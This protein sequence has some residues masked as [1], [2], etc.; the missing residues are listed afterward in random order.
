M[1]ISEQARRVLE[2]S[3]LAHLVT[4]NPNGSPQ[5]SCVWVELDGEEVVCGHLGRSRKVR[6]IEND[7][8]VALSIEAGSIAE[9]G[10]AEYL[11]IYGHARIVK[12]GAPE[13]LRR[14]SRIYLGPDAVFPPMP[15]PPAGFVTRITVDRVSGV[16]PWTG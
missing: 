16:G 2:S 3:H 1:M 12:G 14:L 11:V 15:N 5:L 10:L 4:L 13:L 9:N 7:P 6:N 8:R